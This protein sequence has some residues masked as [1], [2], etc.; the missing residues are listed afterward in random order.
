MSTDLSEKLI[1][2]GADI[3][4]NK[5]LIVPRGVTWDYGVYSMLCD[6]NAETH[7][8][9]HYLASPIWNWGCSMRKLLEAS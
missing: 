1:E 5:N 6:I 7:Q 4:S 3:V 9:E 8:P 2:R